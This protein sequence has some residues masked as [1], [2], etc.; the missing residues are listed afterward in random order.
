[1]KKMNNK[2]FTVIELTLSFIFVFTIAFAMYEL[3]F[4]YRT[5]QNEESIKSQ[6]NDYR[7]EVTLAIQND[8]SDKTLKNIDYCRSGGE[9]IDRCIVLNFNDN[10]S[11]QLSV[12]TTTTIYEGDE[13]EINYINYGGIYY[14]SSDAILLDYRPNYMLYNTYES[15]G[16]DEEI[17]VYKI[18]IPIYHND[19]E[20]NYGIEIVAV[21]YNYEEP[22]IIAG[23]VDAVEATP[24]ESRKVAIYSDDDNSL[25]F[26]NITTDIAIGDTYNSKE[27]TYIYI[28]FE[29]NKF[30]ETD[31]PW[32]NI[33]EDVTAVNVST[34]ITPISTSNWF[35]G[36]I[37]CSS[38]NVSNINMS[39][40]TDMSYMFDSAGSGTS[41]TT[42]TITG[43]NNWDTS[44][45][46]TMAHVFYR[47]GQEATSFSIGNLSNWN[48]AKVQTMVSMFA[49]AGTKATT[50][51]IGNIGNWTTD[52]VN[53]LAY[54][55]Y[56][57]GNQASTWKIGGL[58]GWNTSNVTNMYGLFAATGTNATT[59]SVGDLS[60]WNT[61]KVTSMGYMFY[62]TGF[63]AT[64]YNLG[65]LSGWNVSN[66]TN[67]KQMFCQSGVAASTYKISSTTTLNWTTT[68][69]T[70]MDKM[71]NDAG[72]NATYTLVLSSWNVSNVASDK[73]S[74]FNDGVSSKITAPT[75]VS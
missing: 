71:F 12:E 73:H 53:S 9:I 33:R 27:V 36:F 60:S 68:K 42:F 29:N 23:S 63:K 41:V 7:N 13:Y 17:N 75:W 50:F 26:A 58:G 20:G 56:H 35:R 46:T 1:M 18:S 3:L 54:M 38:F 34:S 52:N 32:Y 70:T 4:N 43:M 24:E 19:L 47:A 22:E 5:R 65:N 69:V 31:V 74:Y 62:K 21:G 55:F 28:G 8:I 44:K 37:N 51:D 66:V 40:V 72:K 15:D 59:W 10:T 6:L 11:K 67:M 14:E 49:Q 48:T 64:S 25:T 39:K 45:V 57:A 2:G 30:S 61:A 16:L